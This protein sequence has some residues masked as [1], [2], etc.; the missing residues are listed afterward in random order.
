[1]SP[2]SRWNKM[3]IPEHLRIEEEIG[4]SVLF[5]HITTS[6]PPSSRVVPPLVLSMLQ[7]SHVE[8]DARIVEPIRRGIQ[9]GQIGGVDD[10]IVIVY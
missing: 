2:S 3:P 6:P 1:M 9:E 7:M 10:G 8:I 5:P 4:A